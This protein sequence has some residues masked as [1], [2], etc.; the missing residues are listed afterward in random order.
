MFELQLDAL[1]KSSK[2]FYNTEECAIITTP[3]KGRKTRNVY[4]QFGAWG[5]ETQVRGR[6]KNLAGL[7]AGA[8]IVSADLQMPTLLRCYSKGVNEKTGN[9][10][11]LQLCQGFF[12]STQGYVINQLSQ[13][14]VSVQLSF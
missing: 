13:T 7:H 12:H 10:S 8:C 11:A 4:K 5:S 6:P 2:F 3:Q 9:V 14:E 1:R